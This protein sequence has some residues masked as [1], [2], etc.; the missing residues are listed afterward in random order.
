MYKTGF[1]VGKFSPLHNGHLHLINQA[2][3]QCERLIVLSYSFPELPGCSAEVRRQ[4]LAQVQ[5]P[6]N[7]D[8]TVLDP[9]RVVLPKND[10]SDWVHR[11]FCAHILRA[12]LGTEV[13]A[14]FSSETYGPGLAEH[15]TRSFNKDRMYK[16]K[17]DHVMV[18]LDRTTIPVSGTACRNDRFTLYTHTRPVVHS[19]FV[20]RVVLLGGESSG[21]TTLAVELA[22]ALGTPWVP[23]YGR[24]YCDQIGGVD[25]LQLQ[26][27]TLIARRQVANELM[28][29][30]LLCRTFEAFQ[31][32]LICDT[33]PLTTQFYSEQMFG[34]V[35]NELR[36]LARR[37][38]DLTIVCEPSF[39]FVQDGTRQDDSFRKIGHEW[40]LSSLKGNEYTIVSGSVE[41]RVEQALAAIRLLNDK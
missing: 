26:D 19:T 14:V 15:L 41:Q 30:Q 33:S 21:K 9:E 31:K 23:E 34:T 17:V 38:Y 18:D 22:Q 40:Y 5:L 4:W 37:Q 25:R 2:A 7:V 6:S 32:P 28:M 3:R 27:L 10:A 13:D 39:P 8:V 24:N 29:A 12:Q 20:H 16:T 36:Q 11:E 35:C 1:V